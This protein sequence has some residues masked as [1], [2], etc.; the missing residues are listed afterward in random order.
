MIRVFTTV[1][2]CSLLAMPIAHAASPETGKL[3]LV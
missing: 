3:T 1:F 2:L